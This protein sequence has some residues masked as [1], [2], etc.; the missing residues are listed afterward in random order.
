MNIIRPNSLLSDQYLNLTILPTLH[1]VY[2][3]ANTVKPFVSVNLSME[4]IFL[5]KTEV[6]LSTK[7]D[8]KIF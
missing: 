4:S 2:M 8:I 6:R 3:H 1:I 7:T 5:D